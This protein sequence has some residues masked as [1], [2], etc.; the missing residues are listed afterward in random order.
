[1]VIVLIVSCQEAQWIQKPLLVL[2]LLSVGGLAMADDVAM[3][4]TSEAEAQPQQAAP[5]KLPARGSTMTHV[6]ASFGAPAERQ[7]AD[8]GKPPITR[9]DYPISLSTLKKIA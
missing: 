3:P 4:N 9:W 6:E 5:M 8:S 2:A 1:M 7:A